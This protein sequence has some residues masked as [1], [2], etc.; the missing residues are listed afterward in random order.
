MVI[1]FSVWTAACHKKNASFIVQKD[2]KGVL[3]VKE[4]NA[5][6]PFEF[7]TLKQQPQNTFQNRDLALFGVDEENFEATDSV[8]FSNSKFKPFVIHCPNSSVKLFEHIDKKFLR[9]KSNFYLYTTVYSE[10]EKEVVFMFDGSRN[11]KVWVNKK[12]VLEVLNKENTIKNCDR[13]LWIKLRKGN[14]TVFVKANRGTNQYSWGILMVVAPEN[15]AQKIFK[16]NYLTDFVNDP[17]VSDSLSIYLG[18]YTDARLKVTDF[19]NKVN[20]DKK[21]FNKYQRSFFVKCSELHDGLYLAKLFLGQDSIEELIYKGKMFEYI[22][23]LKYEAQ[24]LRCEK[25]AFEDIKVAIDRLDFLLEKMNER[26]ESEIR[27]YHRNLLYYARN[28]DAL[29]NYVKKNKNDKLFPGT[30][31][32]TYYSKEDSKVYQFMFH[33]NKNLVNEK[34]MPLILFVP[35]ALV[36]E[37]MSRSWYIGNLDQ[38]ALD[39]R[40]ADNYGFAVAWPFMKGKTYQTSKDAIDDTK[41]VLRVLKKDYNLDTA[42]IYLNGECVGGQRALLL[43]EKCPDWFAG[44]SVRAPITMQGTNEDRPIDFVQNLYNVPVCIQH[45]MDDDRVPIRDT[46]NFAAE[47]QKN[48]QKIKVMETETG[49]LSFTDDERRFNFVYFDSLK[50]FRKQTKFNVV[51]Y[52]TYNQK[53]VSIYWIQLSK[54]KPGEKAEIVANYDSL[55]NEFDIKSKNIMKYNILLNRYNCLK[56]KEITVRSNDSLIFKGLLKDNQISVSIK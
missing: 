41:N 49:H 45:G 20:L 31:L 44:I 7:D 21:C 33:A 55:K 15:M 28:L 35:Y 37:S 56:N 42:Q 46:R 5:I 22:K 50:R 53:P 29:I 13:F 32:K 52:T 54:I 30:I 3:A 19:D 51:K 40:N 43:A 4:W 6:G 25:D 24:K 23:N 16:E 14:N 18:P 39:K 12:Q 11:Y 48:G 34:P 1:T 36:D 17:F 47:A 27:Y 8:K 10:C 9:N 2:F 26:S 38:I